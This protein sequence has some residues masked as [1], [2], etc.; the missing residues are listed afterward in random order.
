MAKKENEQISFRKIENG[1]I[2][3]HSYD[4]KATKKNNEFGGRNYVS[5]DYYAK[6]AKDT[7]QKMI[8]LQSAIT[9]K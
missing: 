9:I 4:E 7:K 3:S 2:V 1:F 8:D 5:K 6:T